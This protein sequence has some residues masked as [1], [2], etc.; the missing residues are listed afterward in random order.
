MTTKDYLKQI[1]KW[2]R[3]IDVMTAQS[4]A[5][6]Q[7]QADELERLYHLASG[8][9]AIT[10]DKERVQVSPDNRLEAIYA[11]IET[12]S[13]KLSEMVIKEKLDLRKK[14]AVYE[15]KIKVIADQ[16]AG[17]DKADHAEI[18]R[19]RYVETE[20]DGREMRLERIAVEMNR[21]FDRVRHLH[22]EALEE[23]RKKYEIH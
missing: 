22:G 18:L 23:F 5:R 6:I 9:K 16:I 17:M 11:K 1:G 2:Q 3:K 15:D 21:T 8:L 14:V 10:Y 12:V 7:R 19:L 4:N 13:S 20:E